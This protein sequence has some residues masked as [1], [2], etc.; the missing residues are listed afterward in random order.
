MAANGGEVSMPEMLLI[1]DEPIVTKVSMPEMLLIRDEQIGTLVTMGFSAKAAGRALGDAQFDTNKAIE[2]LLQKGGQ[3]FENRRKGVA[4]QEVAEAETTAATNSSSASTDNENPNKNK[5]EICSK[6]LNTIM[7]ADCSRPFTKPV[8]ESKDLTQ[9]EK[10]EFYKQTETGLCL[11]DVEW[12][13]QESKYKNPMDFISD[14]RLIARNACLFFT[15]RKMRNSALDLSMLIEQQYGA[16]ETQFVDVVIDDEKEDRSVSDEVSPES[17]GS[18]TDPPVAASRK[19]KEPEDGLVDAEPKKKKP[20]P[21]ARLAKPGYAN[22][23]NF[24]TTSSEEEEE[25]EEDGEEEENSS[26]VEEASEE[27]E[28]DSNHSEEEEDTSDSEEDEDDEEEEEDMVALLQKGAIKQPIARPKFRVNKNF[29]LDKIEDPVD[30]KMND[31]EVDAET[32]AKPVDIN[33]DETEASASSSSAAAPK[34]VEKIVDDLP[35]AAS[36]S[37]SSAVVS[38]PKAKKEVIEVVDKPKVL[39]AGEKALHAKLVGKGK[40]KAPDKKEIKKTSKDRLKE[41]RTAV[42]AIYKRLNSIHIPQPQSITFEPVPEHYLPYGVKNPLMKSIE[43]AHLGKKF[44]ANLPKQQ[45]MKMVT[46]Q[47]SHNLNCKYN[48]ANGQEKNKGEWED[49]IGEVV[50]DVDLPLN[51]NVCRDAI[52]RWWYQVT[53]EVEKKSR[54]DCMKSRN[55]KSMARGSALVTN[56]FAPEGWN[57]GII[58]SRDR[59]AGMQDYIDMSL[60]N[61]DN[62]KKKVVTFL[63]NRDEKSFKQLKSVSG[64]IDENAVSSLGLP[65][66]LMQDPKKFGATLSQAGV[67]NFDKG[68]DFD[69]DL[70]KRLDTFNKERDMKVCLGV[71][72]LFEENLIGQS[73][74]HWFW[75]GLAPELPF[76]GTD[77]KVSQK[78]NHQFFCENCGKWHVFENKRH[79]ADRPGAW[80][81]AAHVL[82]CLNKT[83]EGNDKWKIPHQAKFIKKGGF[84][85][86]L[87][88][89]KQRT[90]ADIGATLQ[91]KYSSKD[92]VKVQLYAPFKSLLRRMLYMNYWEHDGVTARWRMIKKQDYESDIVE[93]DHR[94]LP[95]PFKM[96]NSLDMPAAATPPCFRHTLKGQQPYT[97]SW[98][99]AREGRT[100]DGKISAGC[101]PEAFKSKQLMSRRIAGSDVK[102]EVEVE[103]T[104]DR[105]RGGI[106]GDSPG[107]GKTAC[108]IGLIAQS[109]LKDPM[110]ATMKDWEQRK[111]REHIFTNATLIV[112]PPNLFEQWSDE[113]KK[114]VDESKL[115]LK[116]CDVPDAGYMK[117]KK[118]KQ[119][120]EADVVLVS[121]RFFFSK[122][123]ADW[124]D[125]QTDVITLSDRAERSSGYVKAEDK[126]PL[127]DDMVDYFSTRM[128]RCRHRILKHMKTNTMEEL[129]EMPALFEAFYWKRVVF[130]EFHEV[131]RSGANSGS[132]DNLANYYGLRNLHSRFHWG[133]TATPLLANASEVAEMAS[134]LHIFLPSNDDIQAKHFVDTYM[135]A[136]KWDVE[137][138]KLTEEQVAVRFTPAERALYKLQEERRNDKL[139]DG[140]QEKLLKFCTHFAPEGEADTAE[141][142][143][144]LIRNV[145]KDK[146]EGV[147]QQLSNLH[148]RFANLLSKTAVAD[149]FK[150]FVDAVLDKNPVKTMMTRMDGDSLF[151]HVPVNELEELMN[152]WHVGQ[153]ATF[154]MVVDFNKK[155]RDMRR[156]HHFRQY[157]PRAAWRFGGGQLGDQPQGE[158]TKWCHECRGFHDYGGLSHR[159]TETLV[160]PYHHRKK[161]Y[162]TELRNLQSALQ[163]FDNKIKEIMDQAKKEQKGDDEGCCSICLEEMELEQ[164]IMTKCGHTFHVHCLKECLNTNYHH[165]YHYHHAYQNPMG[166][167]PECR[168]P[169]RLD[170]CMTHK[171]IQMHEEMQKQRD[172]AKTV[173]KRRHQVGS[174][175]FAIVQL[176][177]KIRDEGNGDKVVIFI[178]WNAIRDTL[179]EKIKEAMGFPPHVLKGALTNRQNVLRDFNTGKEA[180]DQVLVLSLEESTSG[181]NLVAANHCL[182]VHPMFGVRAFDE[183][184][185]AI[186]RV[187][188]QGQTKD[189]FV[190]RFYTKDTIE[191]KLMKE[192]SAEFA[193][194][195]D[196]EKQAA[197][198]NRFLEP[199]ID[200]KP[201]NA[202]VNKPK[203]VEPFTKTK[204][205]NL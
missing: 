103:R 104:F 34:P 48:P 62:L 170:D 65:V 145:N 131:V 138:I 197:S 82:E 36:A 155:W 119:F 201:L 198:H 41:Q 50:F 199:E 190:Y 54:F 37:S 193:K 105:T 9:Q 144:E 43:K 163:F 39:T 60:D 14:M 53:D 42:L 32:A 55:K 2:L 35:A 118:M 13:L 180:K 3:H 200:A 153:A 56:Q 116:I 88:L 57:D 160:E 90:G 12:R 178:Q 101:T 164:T 136:N 154:E 141:S 51:V 149:K 142:A 147:R 202:H 10:D 135:R 66:A 179:T 121:F 73:V 133:L 129:L 177:E 191:E 47:S 68:T 28:E 92:T 150:L 195:D 183:E 71:S 33:K 161:Q 165:D 29:Q 11:E 159:A 186:G 31:E 79:N 61:I 40:W 89:F 81:A 117:M 49:T 184:Y 143:I 106:L 75:E 176:L 137:G 99:Y 132:R 125:D 80:T 45:K 130:D 156:T 166:R 19:R 192:H 107:Y 115:K 4:K 205:F 171:D 203:V 23:P 175:V 76:L 139:S 122:A 111:A 15:G 17:A 112:T 24:E 85:Q 7:K 5:F 72:C 46:E 26:D 96:K 6:I 204:K 1:R 168:Q 169:V 94:G 93:M 91:F 134:L 95:E 196:E 20:E 158:Y 98:M 194:R 157:H 8:K 128:L 30:I 152:D 113:F 25:E 185:Q 83:R 21:D 22:V 151:M 188:R 123:Y 110:Q 120:A 181:M 70:V 124:F 27:A 58:H 114:F 97:L 146:Q 74:S 109:H 189:C 77:T 148:A 84:L 52:K 78:L 67:K 64:V 18:S 182:F 44:Q 38:K 174:K 126:K 140:A 102:L 187:R 108:M 69:G 162:E 173:D 16:N 100:H 86:T 63:S 127:P 167:C 172:E 87:R 59:W